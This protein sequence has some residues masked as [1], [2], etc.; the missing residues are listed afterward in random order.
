MEEEVEKIKDL[1]LYYDSWLIF[2]KHF[3]E[4]YKQC[5]HA[6]GYNQKKIC[7]RCQKSLCNIVKIII[8]IPF[9]IC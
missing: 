5:L 1:A 9:R 4:K 8:Q 6:V 7:S 3:S 2:N